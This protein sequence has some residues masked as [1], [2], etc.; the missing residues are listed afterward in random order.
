MLGNGTLPILNIETD[1][2]NPS[3]PVNSID[4]HNN[5]LRYSVMVIDVIDRELKKYLKDLV[6]SSDIINKLTTVVLSIGDKSTT[7]DISASTAKLDDIRNIINEALADDYATDVA[8]YKAFFT[9]DEIK[10]KYQNNEEI[11]N[12]V[13]SIDKL[14]KNLYDTSKTSPASG[15]YVKKHNMFE[16]E[17]YIQTPK[18]TVDVSGCSFKKREWSY[19]AQIAVNRSKYA[20]GNTYS[21]MK[22]VEVLEVL[23]IDNIVDADGAL[24]LADEGLDRDLTPEQI[25]HRS[26]VGKELK[27]LLSLPKSRL[28]Y[29]VTVNNRDYVTAIESIL[30]ANGYRDVSNNI[31][32][33]F[34]I[35]DP[36]VEEG[37]APEAIVSTANIGLDWFSLTPTP[38]I[39][40]SPSYPDIQLYNSTAAEAY[41]YVEDRVFAWANR[42]VDEVKS[43]FTADPIGL[44]KLY[45]TL[46]RNEAAQDNTSA[47]WYTTSWTTKDT[48]SDDKGLPYGTLALT[49]RGLSYA[50]ENDKKFNNVSINS[51]DTLRTFEDSKVYQDVADL[52][53][54]LLEKYVEHIRRALDGL[55]GLDGADPYPVSYNP[56]T[57]ILKG[58]PSSLYYKRYSTLNNRLN[59]SKGTASTLGLL[60][61]NVNS[62][63]PPTTSDASNYSDTLDVTPLEDMDALTYLPTQAAD[64]ST[65]RF[66]IQGKFYST[67]MLDAIRKAVGDKCALTCT[68]CSV[69]SICPFYNEEDIIKMYCPSVN[70]IDVYVKDN[71][72]DLLVMDDTSPKLQSGDGEILTYTSEEFKDIHKVYSNILKA[73]TISEDNVD[74]TVSTTTDTS[75]KEKSLNELQQKLILAF[76][77]EGQQDKYHSKIDTLGWMTGGRYGTVE[78]NPVYRTQSSGVSDVS[79]AQPYKYM[80]DTLFIPD[81]DTYINY[82]PSTKSYNVSVDL[83]K[84]G[85]IKHYTGSTKLYIP[86]G[87][88]MIDSLD[89]N[90]E[91]Y[92]ISDDTKDSLGNK[93]VPVIYL[94]TKK[95][96]QDLIVFDVVESESASNA[97]PYTATITAGKVAQWCINYLKGNCIERPVGSYNNDT[98]SDRDQYWMETIYNHEYDVDGIKKWIKYPGRLRRSASY[99]ELTM[100]PSSSNQ[101]LVISGK[102]VMAD[103]NN[104]VRKMSIKMFTPAEDATEDGVWNIEWASPYSLKDLTDIEK[105]V[106]KEQRRMTLPYMKTNL[107][108][109]AVKRTDTI[110]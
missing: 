96:V 75:G 35:L 92:L 68:R 101:T 52:D 58:N 16:D 56:N 87:L 50:H 10:A 99:Q 71:K 73:T 93:I 90:D 40:S 32:I 67:A 45:T 13:A 41:N 108:L 33:S 5:I 103:Y 97:S 9:N 31:Q 63:L 76:N 28:Y 65:G 7:I 34:K 60:S 26:I 98:Y 106:V 37:S 104:F 102:P 36:D 18:I 80:Y 43:Q 55:T 47:A 107:R 11:K 8:T 27:D 54:D 62:I 57:G 83:T 2:L 25:S 100:T 51:S 94:G 110:S 82:I 53:Q 30:L 105:E 109:V 3:L 38:P 21:G 15:S 78:V 17:S 20:L 66:A 29:Q 88:K 6:Q 23:H 46:I 74:P 81:E 59:K 95:H 49:L 42:E 24:F 85:S 79:D 4:Y 19:A 89:D 86:S 64:S 1:P 72:L 14:V 22:G 12:A 70:Y 39:P 77:K 44:D 69:K 84:D 91:I 48:G 61:S